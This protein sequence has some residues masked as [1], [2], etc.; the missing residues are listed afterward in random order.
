MNSDQIFDAIEEIASTSSKNAKQALVAKY[1]QD[2]QFKRVL[3]AALNP[4]VPYGMRKRPD[5]YGDNGSRE[6]DEGTWNLLDNLATRNLTGGNAIAAV[7]NE[8]TALSPK[9]S[10]LL[11]RI[12]KKDLRAG[13]GESTVNKCFKGL[14]P[15]FPY[16]RCSLPKDTDLNK[17]PWEKGVISQ[18]K[19]DG[20]FANIDHEVG[21]LVRITSRQGSEFP[22]DAFPHLEAEIRERMQ[23]GF[24]YHGEIVVL[25]DDVIQ[26]RQIGNGV[27]NSVLN[28][29]SFADNE[30]PLYLV[31]DAIPLD[32]V[33][34]KGKHN[35]GYKSRLT[36]LI[37]MLK[38]VPGESIELIPTMVS[39]SRA[40][41]MAHYREFLAR[42]KEGTILKHPDAIWKDGTS[43]EQIKLKL[44]VDVDLKVVGFVPGKVGTKNE[45]RTGSLTCVSSCGQLK[46]DVTVKNEA[47]RDDVDA[48]PDAWLDSIVP[49]RAN[50]LL[51][52]SDSNPLHSLY[53]P[54]MV[55]A[56]YRQ[57]KTEADDLQRVRDQFESAIA[58]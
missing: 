18:E 31:W 27:M 58:A 47:M 50:D 54:R 52:P 26:E 6:F 1:G 36:S 45:G 16:M 49:V 53:L 13:F 29:G 8:M 21:G 15:D 37:H 44:E 35:V 17:W 4:L 12:I 11:W 34:C 25:R 20:M 28:G 9:S 22:I 42:G 39:T 56:N 10:E 40:D 41:A 3:E 14:I 46:V 38:S 43:K 55:E 23:A 7:A 32:K 19:A 33:V 57:D 51:S 30:R 24:Q 48:N 2:E 5:L